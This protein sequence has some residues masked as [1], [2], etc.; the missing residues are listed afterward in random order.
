MQNPQ[1]IYRFTCE[2]KRGSRECGNTFDIIA[3]DAL[4]FSIPDARRDA[5]NRGWTHDAD[6]LLICDSC[7]VKLTLCPVCKETRFRYGVS[8]TCSSF[9]ALRKDA[10]LV[11]NDAD[12][13][14]SAL[15]LELLA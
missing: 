9:C 7:S 1:I 4:V 12:S 2:K 8:G 6:S 15:R 14:I 10:A 3:P 5:E 11:D 13:I